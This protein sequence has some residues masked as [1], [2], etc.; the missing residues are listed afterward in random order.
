MVQCHILPRTRPQVWHCMQAILLWDDDME[1]MP[2]VAD[3]VSTAAAGVSRSRAALS[4]VPTEVITH[5][6]RRAW[7]EA[8]PGNGA[9]CLPSAMPGCLFCGFIL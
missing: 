3:D 9:W 7:S 6:L 2:D 1:C 4:E 5:R 8:A